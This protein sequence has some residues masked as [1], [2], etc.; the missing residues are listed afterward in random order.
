VSLALIRE[1]R[2]EKYP[3]K[4]ENRESGKSGNAI[5]RKNGKAPITEKQDQKI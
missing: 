5:S 3:E 4:A 1:G 2:R